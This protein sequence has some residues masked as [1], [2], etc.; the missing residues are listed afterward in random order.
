MAK[1]QFFFLLVT[2]TKYHQYMLNLPATR[3][4]QLNV[5]ITMSVTVTVRR[6]KN[7]FFTIIIAT[8][9]KAQLLPCALSLYIAI[10]PLSHEWWWCSETK[11]QH[12]LESKCKSFG[13]IH[14]TTRW[15][16]IIV[17]GVVECKTKTNSKLRDL[18]VYSYTK[19]IFCRVTNWDWTILFGLSHGLLTP[20]Y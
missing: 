4:W 18:T 14:T 15:I 17:V 13:E 5:T 10:L 20:L 8:W 7:W 19:L 9:F 16:V 3:H 6:K 12:T 2:H 11:W 1:C